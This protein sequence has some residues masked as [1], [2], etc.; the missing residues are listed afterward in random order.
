MLRAS[1]FLRL[2]AYDGEPFDSV[3]LAHDERRLRRRLL[4]LSGG[5]EVMVDLPETT[6]LESG[7]VL[8]LDDG[9]LA[10]IEASGEDLYEVRGGDDL[11]VM[12]LAWHLGNRHLSVEIAPGAD[13]AGHV[14]L[15]RRDH[16]IRDMLLGL[17]ARV[18]ETNGPFS[19]LHGAYH[20]DHGHALLVR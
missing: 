13:G 16:V 10:R 12:Q 5:D 3:T 19:P 15:I 2:G 11:H 20:H 17:G 6:S 1:S 18:V 8:V 14:I 9:R 7:D 4:T